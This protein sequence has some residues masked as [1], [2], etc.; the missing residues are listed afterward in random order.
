MTKDVNENMQSS[1]VYKSFKVKYF[2]YFQLE[3]LDYL[4]FN[5][6]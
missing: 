2:I 5:Y 3:S 1:I 6:F 4:I